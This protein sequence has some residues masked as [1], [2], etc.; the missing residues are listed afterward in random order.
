MGEDKAKEVDAC[1]GLHDTV[2]IWATLAIFGAAVLSL[3]GLPPGH[4][5]VTRV[6]S[7][8]LIFDMVWIGLRPKMV[9]TPKSILAHHLVTLGILYDP[10]TEP[11]HEIYASCALLVE[12]NTVLITLRRTLN[13]AKWVE[14]LFIASWVLLRLL[15]FPALECW[16]FHS[17]FHDLTAQYFPN[18]PFEKVRIPLNTTLLF[19]AIVGLQFFWTISLGKTMLKRGKKAKSKD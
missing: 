5:W 2:N 12:V 9:G 3:A 18:A 10:L 8:Y 7:V 19:G 15:W 11:A 16:F 4:W 1:A 14:F 6:A 13:H 17:T